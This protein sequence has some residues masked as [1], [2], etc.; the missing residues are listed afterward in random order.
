MA[1]PEVF[2]KSA[3]EYDRWF[4]NHEVEYEQEIKAIRELL[5]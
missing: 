2:E 1:K 4:E 3:L 5:P